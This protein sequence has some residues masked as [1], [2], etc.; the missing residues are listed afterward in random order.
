[1]DDEDDAD[2][3]PPANT[4]TF[5]IPNE[6]DLLMEYDLYR[7]SMGTRRLHSER[8]REVYAEAF[9]EN[10]RLGTL[11]DLCVR[12][13]AKMGT[14]YISPLVKH[15]PLKLRVH[16]DALDV[17]LPLKDCYFVDDVRFWRRVVL[18]KS[19]D[20]TLSL[21]KLDEYDW[22]GKGV[23]LKYVEL[24]EACPA[25]YWPE[26]QMAELGSLV[27]QYVR[28]MHI[29]HLQSLTDESF[30]HY[31][32]SEEEL[33]VTSE[34]S[35]VSEISSDEKDTMDEEEECEE[36]EEE[37]TIV[38]PLKKKHGESGVRINEPKA[39]MFEVE[40]HSISIASSGDLADHQESKKSIATDQEAQQ[41]RRQ[42]RNARNAAR[43]QLRELHAE[44]KEEHERRRRNRA[45][46]RIQPEPEPKRK[47]KKKAKKMPIE[48]VFDLAV[49]PEPEDNE[50]KVADGRNKEKLLRRIKRYDYPAKH[51]HHIDLSF[52][53][54][55]DQLVSL[56]IEFL[57]PQMEL[58]YHKRHMNFSYDDMLHLASGLHTLRQLKVFRLRN[59]RMDNIKLLILARVLK[60]LDALEIVDFGFD[61]LNDNCDVALEMLLERTKMYKALELEYNKLER[62]AVEAIGNALRCHSF[63][64]P[65]GSPLE[66]LG[67]AH[68][69]ISDSGLTMLVRDLVGTNHVEELNIN[70]IEC[71]PYRVSANIGFLLRY[72]NPLRRLDM[73]AVMLNPSVGHELLR[74]LETNHKI[75]HF[76]C[77]AC[78]LSLDQEF[79][80]DVIVRRNNYELQHTYLGDETQTEESLL[81]HLAGLRH[82]I[83]TK[84][85]NDL[86]RRDECIRNRP[87]ES[88]TDL[89]V[90]EEQ[91][92][93]Q[94]EEF[95]IWKML[96]VKK[97]V[98][99]PEI[100]RQ[101][102]ISSHQS[103]SG[104]VYNPNAFTLQE[105]REHLYL[106]GP[107]NRYYYFHKPDE[108]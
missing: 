87:S 9:I 38:Q 30:T 53:R 98:I 8:N 75:I 19:S 90:N 79:E 100:E 85:Q 22:K 108:M 102:S 66:Y 70:G 54:Y 18:A 44:K 43:Q 45:L 77:R 89:S 12:A 41:K 63:N 23:S 14:R 29:Q 61:Q 78:D 106:P 35:V 3:L 104:F 99:K 101:S 4:N 11:A 2:F 73:A 74:G 64:D 59:S 92:E 84:I 15:D 50:D 94:E 17:N 58:N 69:P 6:P 60:Q 32:E 1:M 16:Y 82:P 21:K 93:E 25:A 49:E 86:E 97:S 42:A 40:V 56:T 71:P 36:E 52:V 55:F 27:R 76:D 51:C 96:G 20:K 105:F 46:L 91:D 5:A 67:L 10:E 28:T 47:K 26:K 34:E 33:D 24:V 68:N 107:G 48:G 65:D 13:L 103:N 81:Q 83:L 57:G 31:V 72:H 39:R 95:D 88:S 62:T 7:P 80:A 37:V